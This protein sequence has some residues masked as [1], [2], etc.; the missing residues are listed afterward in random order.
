[1]SEQDVLE[2]IRIRRQEVRSI[3]SK[4]S[5]VK[6]LRIRPDEENKDG[7]YVVDEIDQH[8]PM[9]VEDLTDTEEHWQRSPSPDD[10]QRH[11]E[12]QGFHPSS[13]DD[14]NLNPKFIPRSKKLQPKAR[15]RSPLVRASQKKVKEE[16]EKL[17]KQQQVAEATSKDS[18]G[19]TAVEKEQDKP[20]EEPAPA[21]SAKA[22][23]VKEESSIAMLEEI[24]GN[25][26][27]SMTAGKNL[28]A[29]IDSGASASIMSLQTAEQLSAHV[30][31]IDPTR[32]RRFRT[33][34]GEI[35]Q[36][37]SVATFELEHLGKSEFHIIDNG[38][39]PTLIGMT[40]LDDAVLNFQEGTLSR[41]GRVIKLSR[42]GSHFTVDLS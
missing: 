2:E 20:A 4:H 14:D 5:G 18:E 42:N 1:M 29:I 21:V 35:I 17:E 11:E 19:S 15:P 37:I 13:D 23:E 22:E 41:K 6:F 28:E 34:G 24:Q 26:V 3:L 27:L 39:T 33:A 12:L 9:N 16:D 40:S 8:F 36:A 30:V 7:S 10:D 25:E 31:N 38:N 32:Q